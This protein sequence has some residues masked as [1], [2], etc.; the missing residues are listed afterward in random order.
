MQNSLRGELFFVFTSII[1]LKNANSVCLSL[2]QANVAALLL[3]D[4]HL[5]E[6]SELQDV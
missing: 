3:G 6:C 4:L 1:Q 5:K 2:A